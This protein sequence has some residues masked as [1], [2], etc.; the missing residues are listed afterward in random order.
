MNST[1]NNDLAICNTELG[2]RKSISYS[3]IE[4]K[5]P[6]LQQPKQTV[7]SISVCFSICF[8]GKIG[9]CWSDS[10]LSSLRTWFYFKMILYLPLIRR[11]EV[12]ALS[13]VEFFRQKCNIYWTNQFCHQIDWIFKSIV[14]SLW[15]L[16]EVINKNVRSY[17][18]KYKN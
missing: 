6:L 11:A 15:V 14:D 13:H 3:G 9:I 8:K 17:L 1:I 7:V 4:Y 12:S 5:F 16:K 10:L 2:V 18:S